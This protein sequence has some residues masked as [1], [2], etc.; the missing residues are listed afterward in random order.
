MDR[1]E[2]YKSDTIMIT[3]MMKFAV[4]DHKIETFKYASIFLNFL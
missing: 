1:I 4:E 3:K 2:G